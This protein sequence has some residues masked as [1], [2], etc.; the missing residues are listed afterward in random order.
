MNPLD[1]SS[2]QKRERLSDLKHRAEAVLAKAISDP[3]A[4][5]SADALNAAKLLEDL[6]IYQVELELQNE[7]LR[8]AQLAADTARKRYEYLFSQMPI[9]AMVLDAYGMLDDTNELA[10]QL[11]GPRKAFVA[12]DRRLESKFSLKDRARLHAALRDVA[13]RLGSG[14]EIG[15]ASCRERV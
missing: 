6:R 5:I 10:S 15:R 4:D 14:P 7:E 3:A 8:A 12:Y 2:S 1:E 13:V 11:L 9:A